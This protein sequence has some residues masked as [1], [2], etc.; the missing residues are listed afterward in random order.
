MTNI[1]INADNNTATI[2]VVVDG[3]CFTLT[4]E[5]VELMESV[6]LHYDTL[7]IYQ[8]FDSN[9]VTGLIEIA[10]I[11]AG[12]RLD[13]SRRLSVYRDDVLKIG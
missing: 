2:N 13:Y 12:G 1:E 10:P 5:Y 9:R 8:Q 11:T 7:T 4:A 6:E 3:P